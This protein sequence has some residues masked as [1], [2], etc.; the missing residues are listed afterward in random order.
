MGDAQRRGATLPALLLVVS[1]P[2]LAACGW[3]LRGTV[4][5]TLPPA[6]ATLR[7]QMS[8]GEGENDPLL[9]AMRAA[10]QGQGRAKIVDRQDLPTL[11]LYNEV[12]SNRVLSVD[13]TGKVREYMLR[14]EVSFRVTDLHGN[15]LEA[16]QTVILQQAVT[17]DRQHVLE[18]EREERELLVELKRDA[19]QQILQ[20]LSNLGQSG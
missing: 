11:H 3:H 20:R 17:F 12:V 10:L 19:A 5:A 18:K 6:L 15:E 13:S 7:V 9:V 8:G 4:G 1:L 2:L 16:P 14:Y